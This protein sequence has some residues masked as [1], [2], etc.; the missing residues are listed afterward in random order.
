VRLRILLPPTLAGCIQRNAIPAKV[1]LEDE[2][3]SRTPPEKCDLSSLGNLP[4]VERCALFALSQ[5]CGGKLTSFLQLNIEQASELLKMLNH[6]MFFFGEL[7]R[8]G[9]YLVQFKS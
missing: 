2:S 3:G 4:D 9:S 6:G 5:W 7:P 8:Q 1:E